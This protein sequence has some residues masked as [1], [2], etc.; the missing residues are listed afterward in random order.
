MTYA[1]KVS[2]GAGDRRGVCSLA[3]PHSR[4]FFNLQKLVG[5]KKQVAFRISFTICLINFV[6][7]LELEIW[8]HLHAALETPRWKFGRQLQSHSPFSLRPLPPHTLCSSWHWS[9]WICWFAQMLHVST[10]IIIYH[11]SSS[12]LSSFIFLAFFFNEPISLKKSLLLARL[13]ETKTSFYKQ[14]WIMPHKLA[15]E[16]LWLVARADPETI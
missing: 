5:K 4:A 6:A 15:A 16:L 2:A 3:N 9:S 14:N 10:T 12:L 11:S 13:L 1:I 7:Q 8:A